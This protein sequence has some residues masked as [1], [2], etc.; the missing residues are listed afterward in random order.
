[1]SIPAGYYDATVGLHGL[2]AAGRAAQHHQGAHR[3]SATASTA[4]AFQNTDKRPTARCGTC[5]PTS[6]AARRPYEFAFGPLGSG[7]TEGIAYNREHSFPQSW[8]GGSVPPMYSDLWNLYPTDSKVNG[9]R[10]NYPFGDVG[11]AT[12]D[13]A[14]RQQA[15]QRV[16]PGY[17]G[18][19]FEPIDA[20]KGDLVRS[21]FYMADA[22]LQ[23]GRRRGPAAA[24]PTGRDA[25][26][27][28]RP[29]PRVE[30]RPT[31]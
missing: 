23:R 25:A 6:R 2:G 18:T 1:M 29:V 4:T 20:Y 8:F 13:V 9:Y 22:L 14:Q 24:R 15:R 3:A 17:G 19:V 26:V 7:G 11:T 12:L 27:G 5:T 28:G 31:R 10:G 21:Q 16:S 30:R